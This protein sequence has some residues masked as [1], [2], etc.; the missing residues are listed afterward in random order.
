MFCSSCRHRRERLS[1]TSSRSPKTLSKLAASLVLLQLL[2]KQT[3]L[4]FVHVQ[5]SSS[6]P[7]PTTSTRLNL[8]TFRSSAMQASQR[9]TLH[10]HGPHHPPHR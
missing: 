9:Q 2:G 4:E 8:V 6:K 5:V 1:C 10:N 3:H 7:F